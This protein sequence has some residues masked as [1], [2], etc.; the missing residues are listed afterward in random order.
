M[1]CDCCLL[2]LKDDCVLKNPCN[3]RI[4]KKCET[5]DGGC[6]RCKKEKQMKAFTDYAWVAVFGVLLGVCVGCLLWGGSSGVHTT[7]REL[8]ASLTKMGQWVDRSITTRAAVEKSL[9]RIKACVEKEMLH[10]MHSN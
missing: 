7:V 2:E 1:L 4:H 8:Q 10:L 5:E 3:H 6:N 9:G